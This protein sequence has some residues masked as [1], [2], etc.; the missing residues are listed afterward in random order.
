MGAAKGLVER[1]L[2]SASDA[3][4]AAP[5]PSFAAPLEDDTDA[6]ADALGAAPAAKRGALCG[7]LAARAEAAGMAL[8]AEA[9]G[10]Q[11]DGDDDMGEEVRG[12]RGEGGP[13]RS[14]AQI[15]KRGEL[16]QAALLLPWPSNGTAQ[17][18]EQMN[19]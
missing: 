19:G 11:N 14:A 1:L 8:R 9:R 6:L 2:A 13:C 18:T 3:K 10:T 4:G 15:Q 12:R 5:L 16:L 7:A 17:H